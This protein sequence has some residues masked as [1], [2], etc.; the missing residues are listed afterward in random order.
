MYLDCECFIKYFV[1]SVLM[2][3][4][5]MQVYVGIIIKHKSY[6]KNYALGLGSYHNRGQKG[7]YGLGS[8]HNRGQ[9][10]FEIFI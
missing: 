4:K 7:I 6:K 5:N 9:T 2:F 3:G 10:C 8:D 1:L